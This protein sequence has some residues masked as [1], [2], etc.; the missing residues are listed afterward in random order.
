MKYD[1]QTM[2]EQWWGNG[3]QCDDYIENHC[4]EN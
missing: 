2:H 3:C 1:A 4:N